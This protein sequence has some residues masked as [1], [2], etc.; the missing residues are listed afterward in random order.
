[1]ERLRLGPNY[2]K[3]PVEFKDDAIV[4]GDVTAAGKIE[5]KK[6]SL[7]QGNIL[8]GDDIVLKENVRVEG[9][10]T[11]AGKVR[12]KR[13]AVVTGTIEEHADIPPFEPIEPVWL[14]LKAGYSD[15]RVGKNESRV[16][17]PGRYRKLEVKEHAVLTLSSGKYA[18][19]SFRVDKKS[20]IHLD[21]MDGPIL[22]KVV[23]GLELKKQIKMSVI[24]A[25]GDIKDIQFQVGEKADFKKEGHYLGTYLGFK[26]HM[27]LKSWSH[28]EG[29]LYGR[30]VKV[31]ESVTVLNN[32]LPIANAGED[33]HAVVDIPIFLDGSDSYDPEHKRLTFEWR[34]Q[35]APPGSRVDLVTPTSPN[36][37][38]IPDV[39]GDYQ[40]ELIVNDG[41]S[42]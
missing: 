25:Q 9:D 26:A 13:G 22:I 3:E 24:S 11:A 40:F 17:A 21:L 42:T 32:A 19:K 30:K 4:Q 8:S 31:E 33:L 1:M 41:L 10:V 23:K 14:F 7:V 18:F 5:L 36:P 2:G 35:S 12:L 15:I 28:L 39:A 16:L 34:L 6:R 29:A 37:S 27:N 38:F 20:R